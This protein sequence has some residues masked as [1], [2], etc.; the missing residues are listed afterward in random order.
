MM[1]MRI[2]ARLKKM[3]KNKCRI[4]K[5]NS[6]P[7]FKGQKVSFFDRD[8]GIKMEVNKKQFKDITTEGG[9]FH[10]IYTYQVCYRKNKK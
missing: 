7:F 10:Q 3:S 2:L 9:H 5:S 1:T 6:L 8:T 4:F